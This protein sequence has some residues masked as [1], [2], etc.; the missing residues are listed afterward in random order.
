MTM[1]SGP[2]MGRVLAALSGYTMQF[3]E[4]W[5]GLKPCPQGHGTGAAVG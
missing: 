3:L 4:R 5:S 2:G 1:G